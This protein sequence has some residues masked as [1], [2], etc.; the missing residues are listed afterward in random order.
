MNSPI[1][2]REFLQKSVA[3]AG[4]TIVVSATPFGYRIAKAE[5][6]KKE[7]GL[8]NPSLWIEIKPNNT[9]T[10]VVNKSEMGQGV[11]TSLPMIAAEELEADWRLVGFMEA[12]AGKKY[13]DPNWGGQQ[14]TGGST[15]V[16]H[17]Y[18]PLRR[19]GATART[20]LVQAAAQTWKV[21]VSECIAS[22]SMVR[23]TRSGRTLTYGD[24][25]EKASSLP[26]PK[27]VTLRK[28]SQFTIIGRPLARLDIPLKVEGKAQ[29]GIDTFLPEM[30]YAA[31]ARPPAY[32]AKALSYDREA[33][34]KVPGV[35]Q[36]V[37]I[38]RGIAVCATTLDS[39]WKAREALQVKWDKGSQPDLDN[40]TLEKS[41]LGYLKEKGL[42]AK[43]T[44]DVKKG[45]RQ[46]AKRIEATYILPYLAHV[47][48][49]PMNCTAHVRRDQCEIW[50]PTQNQ[51]GTLAITGKITGF[52][53]D[54]I[55]VH[56]TYLG[57]GFGRRAAT[58]FVEEAVE[59][60]QAVGKPIKLIWTREEDI[61]NDFYRPG[62]SCIIRGGIDQKGNL[63]AW[64]Q[65]IAVQSV[66]AHFAPQMIK[67]GID[68]Q[69]VEG[70]V[71]ME[72]KI[73]NLL[74]EYV[75][76]H[77]PIPVGFW[78]SVG[79]SEN[80][81]TKESFM[82]ELAA[83]AKKDPFEFRLSLLKNHAGARR[84]LETAAKKAEWGKPI[85]KGQGRGI[86]FHSSFESDVA[87][88]AEVSV[89]KKDGT[90]KVH[91]V[92][93]A[94]DCGPYV[95]P[96]IIRAN[97]TGAIIMGLSAALR[98]RVDFSSGGVAS[99]NFYNYHELRMSEVPE[100]EVHI[101]KGRKTMGGIGEPGLPPIAPA[102]ANAVF[103]AIGIRIRRLPLDPATILQAIQKTS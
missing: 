12:P 67:N 14:L 46:S 16:R 9:T 4:L 55:Q 99:A 28:E 98:E 101:V 10:I 19:A 26:I 76:I 38:D 66:F 102:V 58:D 21:P 40:Q 57:G 5:D 18:E 25:T 2:R 44:G 7:P 85:K 11:C 62:N 29:F 33:A 32:G 79:N 92:V 6:L 35:H 49:E 31:V 37:T 63:V 3:F 94:V 56:T 88:V 64:S 103:S 83:A 17:M 80:A 24:L 73:P 95:N 90:I 72:Y 15:S 77:N 22:Q 61:K 52:K 91:R 30:L 82:D 48:M 71:N 36:V 69:A 39:A 43:S 70:A 75:R 74:V 42:A 41:L 81:F 50:A 65:R 54:R 53:P 84:V 87:E 45:L 13:G 51:S 59:I 97:V 27:S 78:R 93:C 96:A 86:A 8:F 34:M 60:S 100:I 23:H 47:T 89:N 20:M 68:P 1:T